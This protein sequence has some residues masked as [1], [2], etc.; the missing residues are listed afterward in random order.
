[1]KK[2]QSFAIAVLLLI[3]VSYSGSQAQAPTTKVPPK[4]LRHV[5]LF[6]F[7]DD[8]KPEDVQKVETF[9]RSLAFR[10]P[11]IK[12]FEWGIN[13]SP[14]NLNQGLTHCFSGNLRQ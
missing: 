9:F 2:I 12:D 1:M 3:C 14:E 8:A 4:V 13:N 11:L 6:K 5:V 7:K 10:I